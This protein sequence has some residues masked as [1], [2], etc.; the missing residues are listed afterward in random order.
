MEDNEEESEE[1]NFLHR[2]QRD[3]LPCETCPHDEDGALPV[4]QQLA[5]LSLGGGGG[6]VCAGGS[7]SEAATSQPVALRRGGEQAL[8]ALWA[9]PRCDECGQEDGPEGGG[10]YGFSDHE[11]MFFCGRCWRS[12]DD[13]HREE[14]LKPAYQQ[15]LQAA[16]RRALAREERSALGLPGIT[17]APSAA[18]IPAGLEASCTPQEE[19]NFFDR[20]EAPHD[21][22]AEVEVEGGWKPGALGQRRAGELELTGSWERPVCSQCNREEGDEGGGRYRHDSDAD[23]FFCGRCWKSWDEES[24]RKMMMAYAPRWRDDFGGPC[25]VVDCPPPPA[26]V[27]PPAPVIL[28]DEDFDFGSDLDECPMPPEPWD[29]VE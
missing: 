5:N 17:R 15:E 29:E 13:E 22:P 28:G 10:R 1:D 16:Q 11:G 27:E 14:I 3:D 9:R 8:P 4:E 2:F 25:P 21:L 24:R 6:G 12:W 7:Y 19:A 26:D 18:S 23:R 20:Y